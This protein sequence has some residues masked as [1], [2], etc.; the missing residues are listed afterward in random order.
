MHAQAA[1]FFPLFET[2][3]SAKE[4]TIA[5]NQVSLVAKPSSKV[6][7]RRSGEHLLS[8]PTA[9]E[10]LGLLVHLQL[11]CTILIANPF[12]V[13][14]QRVIEKVELIG[15]NL[16]IRGDGFDLKLFGPNFHTIRLVNH[17]RK[18][19]GN[20]SLDMHDT[21]GMLYASIQ[22]MPDGTGAAV[23]RDIMENPSLSLV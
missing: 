6:T 10:R 1:P 12:L 20:T 17:R 14:R 16:S 18:E 15:E 21:Q 13:L 19:D 4:T 5:E 8:M 11:P 23:W 2:L 9:Y 22:P 7:L 3:F